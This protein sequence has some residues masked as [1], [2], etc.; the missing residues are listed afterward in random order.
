MANERERERKTEQG[1]AKYKI[2]RYGDLKS[3]VLKAQIQICIKGLTGLS[4]LEAGV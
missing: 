2:W 3:N 4:N 1:Q